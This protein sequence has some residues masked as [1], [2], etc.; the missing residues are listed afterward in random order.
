VEPIEEIPNEMSLDQIN[1]QDVIVF[2]R[3]LLELMKSKA[4][5]STLMI[6]LVD[7]DWSDFAL[8]FQAT[9]IRNTGLRNFVLI[10]LDN[11]V[12]EALLEAGIQCGIL[13]VNMAFSNESSDF[14]SASY[15]QKTNLKTAVMLEVLKLNYSV[16]MI[17]LDVILFKDPFPFFTCVECDIHIQM[18]RAL[19][20]SGF[21]FARPTAA[22]LQL[23]SRAWRF[24]IQYHKAHD[25]AYINMA[26]RELLQAKN[27]QI[28]ELSRRLF[29]CGIYY[30]QHDHRMFYNLPDCKECVMAHNNYIGSVA[31]KVYRFRENLLW[32]VNTDHYYDNQQAKFLT[33]IN[34]DT[35]HIDMNARAL[36]NA[37]YISQ[38][39]N[40]ILILPDFRC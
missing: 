36:K 5:N 39:L 15:Y 13:R 22:S 1:T 29:P 20:N 6:G 24:Y 33:Y 17:D 3:S 12:S 11:L 18:D 37:L 38:L 7:S 40:R 8:N 27:I 31:A 23:Y 34:K 9:S 32:N 4:V 14:G 2:T 26:A 21:V 10:C 35:Q 16:L 28:Q 19:L 25:Q 30:F